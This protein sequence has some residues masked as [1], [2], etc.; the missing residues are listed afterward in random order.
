MRGTVV[1]S[2]LFAAAFAGAA[3]AQPRPAPAPP[4]IP[5]RSGYTLK[6]CITLAEQNYPKIGEAR[7]RLYQKE[8]Q[9]WQAKTAPFSEFTATGGLGIAPSVRGTSIY[10]PESDVSLSSNMG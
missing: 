5:V 9:L 7:A 10:S 1:R 3:S 8:A 6:R 4:V 2:L